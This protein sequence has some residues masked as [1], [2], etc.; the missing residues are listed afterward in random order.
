[1]TGVVGVRLSDY[2]HVLGD[3]EISDD[4]LIRRDNGKKKN[5]RRRV[6]VCLAIGR[7]IVGRSC[8]NRL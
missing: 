2:R 1:M 7:P 5:P 6:A 8:L 3:A 4:R